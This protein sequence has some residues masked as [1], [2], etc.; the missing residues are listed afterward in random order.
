MR[1]RVTEKNSDTIFYTIKEACLYMLENYRHLVPEWK[2]MG[3]PSLRHLQAYT[4]L[5]T[6]EKV[7]RTV[8]WMSI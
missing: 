4:A 1:I 3:K 6:I 2:L 8:V 7:D 5:V